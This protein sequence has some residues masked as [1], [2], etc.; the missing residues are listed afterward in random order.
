[1]KTITIDFETFWS[2]DFSLTKVNFIEYIKSPQFEIIS[3]AIKEGDGPTRVVFG[4]AQVIAALQAIDWANAA[5][6]CHNGNEFDFPILVWVCDCHPKLFVDTLCLSRAKHMNDAG[7]SL[8]TLSEHYGLPKKD[9]TALLNTKGRRYA[10]FSLEDMAGMAEY[11][12]QDV[13]NTYALFKEFTKPICSASSDLRIVA[14]DTKQQRAE[15][16][17]SDMTA[18]MI[19]YPRFHCDTDLVKKT[20][21]Q[22]EVD[23]HNELLSV[24]ALLGELDAE[25]ALKALSSAAKFAE[26]LRNLGVEPPTKISKTT[27]EET[28]ALAKTDQEFI[29]LQEHEDERVQAVVAARL[30]AKSTLLQTRL[31]TMLECADWMGGAMPVPLGYHAASTGRWGG[32]VW[33]PQNLSRV[34]RRKDGSIE[35]KASNALRM[36]LVA[37][38]GHKVVVSDLSGIELR[39][40]HYLWAVP[41]TEE[42]YASNAEADLYKEFAASLFGVPREQVTKDQR[43]IAKIAQLG[44]G[45][46]SG[47]ATFKRI[48]KMMGGLDIDEAE[49]ERVTNA[50]RMKYV[51]IAKGWKACQEA[52]GAMMF[53][54]E[55][56]IDP[57]G[58]VTT[59]SKG[60]RLPSGRRLYYPNLRRIVGESGRKEY[61]YGLGRKASKIYGGKLD[62]NIVQAIARD[63]IAEQALNVLRITGYYPVLMVHDEL[64]YV[65]P[66]D[67]AQA[68]LDTLSAVMRTSPAWLPGIV[69]WSEGD[70]AQSYGEAK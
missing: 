66:E 46:Q 56:S 11:N 63:V 68:H 59:E 3:V 15:W 7:G 4:Q 24:A 51:E 8:K 16:A 39:V 21:A 65:I 42:L 48:A 9:Q 17:L 52:L 58:L 1:M 22:V 49:A 6:V 18:R 47:A 26:V 60:L 10:D 50:W 2:T 34:A 20:L 55:K 29:D 28:Y 57:R 19:C 36:S 32:R 41:S 53:G 23:K 35:P 38:P 40:N 5:C 25:G 67:K 30:G 69:L 62:E 27:G 12:K 31:S 44:L 37:P 70:I 45:F 61:E 43:Q 13:Y 64:V 54:G 33:N 14:L